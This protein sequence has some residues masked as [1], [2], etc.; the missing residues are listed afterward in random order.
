MTSAL[1]ASICLLTNT[2]ACA[3][4]RIDDYLWNRVQHWPL[5]HWLITAVDARPE[6]FRPVA[7]RGDASAGGD[8][9]VIHVA[10]TDT[11]AG[12]A[13]F[14]VFFTRVSAKEFLGPRSLRIC[15]AGDQVHLAFEPEPGP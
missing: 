11:V 10:K 5:A 3:E 9:V 12:C 8:D 15:R 4:H 6:G 2:V 7:I 1:L 13:T 14:R